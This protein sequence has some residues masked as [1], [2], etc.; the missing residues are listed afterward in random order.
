MYGVMA[1]GNDAKRQ[2]MS[3]LGQ[4]VNNERQDRQIKDQTARNEEA[5][6]NGIIGQG[7]GMGVSRYVNSPEPATTTTDVGT[8]TNSGV[9]NGATVATDAATTTATDAGT[10]VATDAATTSVVDM[11]TT[12][13][14]DAAATAA[15]DA[16]LTTAG[17]V[18]AGTEAG[19]VAGP[20]GVAI[21][22]AA[23]LLLSEIM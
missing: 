1:Q 6:K 21:G 8:A 9:T 14:A 19:S 12:A 15:V 20:W 2:S 4:L 11:G 7:I 18:T 13:A 5:Q 23:G 3:S 16:G 22:A 10:T 17:S